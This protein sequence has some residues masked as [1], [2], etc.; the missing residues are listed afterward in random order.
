MQHFESLTI[1]E[2]PSILNQ[3]Q[4]RPMGNH[5]PAR[6]ARGTRSEHGIEG[7]I[8]TNFRRHDRII[9]FAFDESWIDPRLH[10]AG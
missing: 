8:E 3:T 10:V 9:R 1:R 4:N 5:R 6:L 7:R 2:E